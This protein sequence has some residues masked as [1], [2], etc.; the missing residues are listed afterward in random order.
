MNIRPDDNGGHGGHGA[1]LDAADC[2]F[3]FEGPDGAIAGHGPARAVERGPAATLEARLARAMGNHAARQGA[4]IGGALPF[5]KQ[6]HDCLW[7][8]VSVSFAPARAARDGAGPEAEPAL[9][10]IRALRPEP[11]APDFADAVARA[12]RIMH[13]EDG[14]PD[15]LAKIVLSR[16][17][18]VESESP[19]PLPAILSRLAQDPTVTTFRT[20]LPGGVSHA[21]VG[22]TPELL[23]R[24]SGGRIASHPLAGSARRSPDPA[25]DRAAAEALSRS[26]KDRREHGLVVEYILD[27]LAPFCRELSCPEGTT[28]THTR[29]MWHLGTRIEGQLSDD[30]IPSVLLAAR[31]HPTPAVCGL[32]VAR[33]AALIGAL[34]PVRRGFYAGAVGW[35]DA[36]GDGAWFVAIRC[37]EIRGALARLHAGAGIVPGSDPMA[38]A[39]ETGAKFGALL[40]ALGLP[41][42]AGMAGVEMPG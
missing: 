8:A 12:L 35:C 36:R 24:K 19:L 14:G 33:A 34:E 5:D 10:A 42:D 18:A 13:D 2:L 6:D 3:S 29:S 39:A 7:Q 22:A 25:Q 27:M 37:A 31:L 11:P 1:R 21:L 23:L 28:L 32:P 4:V 20:R 16:S 41:R 26:D 30:A 38:E 15:A 40:A 9:P 17:L